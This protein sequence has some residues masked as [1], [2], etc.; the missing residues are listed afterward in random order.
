[1]ATEDLLDD[2]VLF[3]VDGSGQWKPIA[4]YLVL[5]MLHG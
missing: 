4:L 2:Q 1:M 5:G 3:R